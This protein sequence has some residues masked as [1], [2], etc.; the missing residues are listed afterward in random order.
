MIK[1]IIVEDELPAQKILISFIKDIPSL[2]LTATFNNALEAMDFFQKNEVDLMFL[3]IN[4][5]KLS[6]LNFLRS[7]NN[8][9]KVIITTAYPNYALDGFELDVMD[10]LLK[11]FSF[12]RFI[13]A[14][15]K[16]PKESSHETTIHEQVQSADEKQDHI[17]IKMDRSHQKVYLTNILFIESDKDFVK[18]HQQDKFFMELQSL[19]FYEHS[20]PDNFIRVH[21]SYIVNKNKIETVESSRLIIDKHVIPI[22]RNF[23]EQL[24]KKIGL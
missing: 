18:L 7:I 6:G 10:Y 2:S 13:K 23:K 3:D 16:F 14:V 21:K 9:P 15:N 19:K 24:F 12:E 4:L 1:C 20:L 11:P 8:S 17:F 22:G 5:P